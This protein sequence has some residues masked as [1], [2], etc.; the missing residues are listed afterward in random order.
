[1]SGKVC[2]CSSP[3]AFWGVYPVPR[4]ERKRGRDTS[5]GGIRPRAIRSLVSLQ[6]CGRSC[7]CRACAIHI[8]RD[9]YRWASKSH[10]RHLG[11]S[12]TTVATGGVPAAATPVVPTVPIIPIVSSEAVPDPTQGVGGGTTAAVSPGNVTTATGTR[13]VVTGYEA[14]RVHASWTLAE[15]SWRRPISSRSRSARIWTGGG[16]GVSSLGTWR[17]WGGL[18]VAR[19]ASKGSNG[20]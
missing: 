6:H 19:R 9:L 15:I 14:G 18:A 17:L 2:W 7:T 4:R 5:R 3:R 10:T 13:G 20:V 1:M 16:P 8:L 12:T 11:P